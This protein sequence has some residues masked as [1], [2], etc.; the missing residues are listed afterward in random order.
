MLQTYSYYL[1]FGS[2]Y[3]LFIQ[4]NWKRNLEFRKSLDFKSLQKNINI[5][6]TS[7]ITLVIISESS[8]YFSLV[9]LACSISSV[10]NLYKIEIFMTIALTYINLHRLILIIR[11]Y[12][13]N[14]CLSLPCTVA[15]ISMTFY[16]SMP[17]FSFLSFFAEYD[18]FLDQ[19]L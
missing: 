10:K 2:Q 12:C 14:T 15:V 11:T 9:G 4:K 8:S 17:I 13:K 19:L 7:Q 5:S 6:Y 16:Y 18:F 1:L 3:H